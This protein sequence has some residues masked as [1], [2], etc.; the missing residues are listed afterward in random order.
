MRIIIISRHVIERGHGKFIRNLNNYHCWQMHTQL[1]NDRSCTDIVQV[2]LVYRLRHAFTSISWGA[3]TLPHL[4]VESLPCQPILQSLA[5]TVNH[6]SLSKAPFTILNSNRLTFEPCNQCLQCT[7]AHQRASLLWF[8]THCIQIQVEA[9]A[10]LWLV[11]LTWYMPCSPARI[12][13]RPFSL[14]F[15]KVQF[16]LDQYPCLGMSTVGASH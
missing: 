12:S 3:R 4:Q 15:P 13:L 2:I 9:T 10:I 5:W 16:Y 7:G 8:G 6:S 14:K 11:A 1:K